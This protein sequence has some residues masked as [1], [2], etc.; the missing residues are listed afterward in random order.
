MKD[1]IIIILSILAGFMLFLSLTMYSRGE[2]IKY[3]VNYDINREHLYMKEV[4]GYSY[5]PYCGEYIGAESEE[6]E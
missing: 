1:T 5:C 6:E 2:R 3:V 4:N